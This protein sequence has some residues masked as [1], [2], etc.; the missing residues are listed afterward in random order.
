MKTIRAPLE[1]VLIIEPDMYPD[2]R[3]FFLE[4]YRRERYEALGIG[5]DFVQ[6]NLSRSR[7]HTLRGLHYQFPRPQAKLVQVVQGDVFD[8]S[9]DI[10][11]GSPDFGR[12]FGV[13][14]TA[15][16][17]RQVFVPQGFA[18]G[19][20]ALTDEA[21]VLYKCSDIYL[22]EHDAGILWSDPDLGIDWPVDD[23]ILSLKDRGLPRLQD[24][25]AER[26]P[27]YTGKTP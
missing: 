2:D 15:K 13:R 23:P 24:V 9:V 19:F 21:R 1:E 10:R 14:L 22:P 16:E 4:I 6:D 27:A 26:L 17:G 20:C 5:L 3:G 7:R 8:V 18:H 11:R 12:W 25:A